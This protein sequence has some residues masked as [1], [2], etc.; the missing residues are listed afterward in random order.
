MVSD[1]D[2]IIEQFKQ[3][4]AEMDEPPL[5]EQLAENEECDMIPPE[6]HDLIEGFDE[7][8]QYRA[9][10][11][12]AYVKIIQVF[13]QRHKDELSEEGTEFLSMLIDIGDLMVDGFSE[14]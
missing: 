3:L 10:A 6:F 1:T 5:S 13:E 11:F 9:D 8:L 12:G 2:A 4:V 14:K 7:R